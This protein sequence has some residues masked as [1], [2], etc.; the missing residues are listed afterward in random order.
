M[1]PHLP[2]RCPLC[3][4]ALA[5]NSSGLACANG[6]QFDRARRGHYHLLP[7]QHKASKNPGDSQEMVTARSQFL[8][9]GHYEPLA[10]A[11]Q[12]MVVAAGSEHVLDLGC[13]EGYYSHA[14]AQVL[15]PEQVVGL[16]ISK[17]MILQA[18]KQYPDQPWIVGS[19]KQLP[20][21]DQQLDTIVC[22]F[23]FHHVAE[24]LRTLTPNGRLIWVGPGT[25]HLLEMRQRLYPDVTLKE[26][27][28]P[29]DLLPHFV[30]VDQHDLY[31]SMQLNA[32]E[33]LNLM[34]MT[35]HY[36]RAKPDVRQQVASEG[37]TALRAS[38]RISVLQRR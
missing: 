23:A 22:V 37:F 14:L 13:G 3:L 24:L 34:K 2:L 29:S 36:W 18:S 1:L 28:L 16:D 38:M 4:Q 19:S 11:L 8:N 31:W 17:N 35:P 27:Q 33:G 26:A 12:E 21:F 32:D 30:T 20:F 5:A 15:P 6:H 9:Q 25:E 7:V 10:E